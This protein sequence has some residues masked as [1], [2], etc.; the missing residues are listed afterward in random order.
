MDITPRD[1]QTPLSSLAN[2]TMEGA[3]SSPMPMSDDSSKNLRKE[4]SKL[5]QHYSSSR[6][7]E[8]RVTMEWDDISYDIMVKDPENSK[9]L[10][11]KYRTK[12]ILNH[13]SGQGNP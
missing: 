7:K 8:D 6:S 10:N 13:L 2:F 9:P 3:P 1:K 11:P 12:H 5:F 4:S